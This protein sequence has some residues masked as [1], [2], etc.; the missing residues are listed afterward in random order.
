MQFE[1]A[2]FAA[3]DEPV[4]PGGATPASPYDPTD[5]VY[6][7]ARLLCAN[8][9]S[10]GADLA[11]AVYAYNHSAAYVAQVLALAQSYAGRPPGR[12]RATA[13][14]RR[15][16]RGGRRRGVGT[17][18]DRHAR[19]SGAVRPRG[20]ASTA[21]ASSR[22]PTA[23]PACHCRGWRRTSTTPRPRWP[24]ASP[25]LPGDLVFFGGGPG[26]IDHVGLF[27]GIVGGQDVMVDAPSPGADVRAEYFP[28]TAGAPSGHCAS[29]VRRGRSERTT[30]ASL[31][32]PR[33]GV[34]VSPCLSSHDAIVSTMH[35]RD[36]DYE[37]LL[38]LRTG[39]RRFLRWSDQQAEAA[40]LT[41]AQHQL[42]WPIR[43]HS[44]PPGADGRRG[45]RL[46]AAAPPQRG[47]P[48]G[49]CRERRSDPAGRDPEDHRVVRLQLTA[50]AANGSRPSRRCTWKSSSAWH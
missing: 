32:L 43:G 20:S 2:T 7:A 15:G 21:R 23:R 19:T 27:V 34:A 36:A 39:L 22:P 30:P 41:P 37:D 47:W 1:P 18:A 42:C 17:G 31:P 35:L 4:P 26:A 24:R 16:G 5:A 40:G 46:S 6:A 9:A 3:Y 45:G 29:S 38:A 48:R 28:G 44:R 8:G 10:G 13:G 12:R 49:P 33:A 50:R 25:L 14:W 11:G